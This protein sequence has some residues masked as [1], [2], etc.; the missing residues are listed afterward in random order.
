MSEEEKDGEL[1]SK[2]KTMTKY[3]YLEKKSEN[4]YSN[5]QAIVDAILAF[6]KGK[7]LELR[8]KTLTE[9]SDRQNKYYWACVTI[10]ANELGY[11]KEEM[12]EIIKFK[13]LK[14]EKV[15]ERTGEIFNYTESTVKLNKE[16]FGEFMTNL[17]QWSAQS[18]GIVLPD[19]GE[20]LEMFDK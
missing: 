1:L 2:N 15:D 5:K 13:L 18:L 16:D 19:P 9:R 3:I 17:Q 12:H 10:M 4:D 7:R 20:K 6:P 11:S 14:R 8:I